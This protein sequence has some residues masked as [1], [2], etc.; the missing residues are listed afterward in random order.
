MTTGHSKQASSATT[1]LIY[2]TV[3]ALTVVWTIIRYVY[4]ERHDGSDNTYLWTHG[5]LMSGIV[6]LIIGLALGHI[7]RAARGAEVTS[8]PATTVVQPVPDP[9]T[10]A[11]VPPLATPGSA[12]TSIQAVPPSPTPNAAVPIVAPTTQ[13]S[14][15]R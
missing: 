9:P 11:T 10:V 4:L 5:F 2:I 14:V 12:A 15:V 7:G 3:G 1:S 8:V 6:L 13:Y